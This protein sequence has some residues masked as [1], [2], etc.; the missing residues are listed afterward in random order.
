MML[1]VSLVWYFLGKKPE[2]IDKNGNLM[3]RDLG[4]LRLAFRII[5]ALFL[6]IGVA[7]LYIGMGEWREYAFLTTG[8]LYVVFLLAMQPLPHLAYYLDH[9]ARDLRRKL[10]IEVPIIGLLFLLILLLTWNMETHR[11]LFWLILALMPVFSFGCYLF[12][13]IGP[14]LG[15][16]L[17]NVIVF[18]GITMVRWLSPPVP[19]LGPDP[20]R[21]PE[22]FENPAIATEPAGARVYLD[23]KLQGATPLKLGRLQ[24][25]QLMVVVKDGYEAAYR[26]IEKS[27]PFYLKLEEARNRKGDILLLHILGNPKKVA[28][29]GQV[30]AELMGLGWFPSS[31][32]C[33]A[34]FNRELAKAG[35]SARKDFLVWARARFRTNLLV[36]LRL[37]GAATAFDPIWELTGTE[38]PAPDD[39][40]S[41][42]ATC[43]D[44]RKGTV[45]HQFAI[46]GV[47]WSSSEAA[48]S[49]VARELDQKLAVTA[50]RTGR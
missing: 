1:P 26:N 30:R 28:F 32:E 24:K 35:A 42:R 3:L 5:A 20:N 13:R 27:R 45:T 18:G 4:V 12:F 21:V 43:F 10:A 22:E 49:Q 46:K 25:N 8:I 16:L 37:H 38:M 15:T 14:H 39:Y 41:L 2:R 50:S 48:A 9:P 36:V 29:A 47:T 19:D 6:G 40:Q 44:L 33:S 34:Q 23:W 11:A 31:Y 7:D 17:I